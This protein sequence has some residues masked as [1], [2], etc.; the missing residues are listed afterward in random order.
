MG[1]LVEELQ[2]AGVVGGEELREHQ[3]AKQLGEYGYR[4]EEAGSTRYPA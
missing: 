3:A 1:I 2:L 4:Q